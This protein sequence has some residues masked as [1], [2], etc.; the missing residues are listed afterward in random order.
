MEPLHPLATPLALLSGRHL[1]ASA[2]PL[3]IVF[4]LPFAATC[5]LALPLGAL[6]RL[7]QAQATVVEFA[8]K[9]AVAERTRRAEVVVVEEDTTTDPPVRVPRTV[10]DFALVLAVADAREALALGAPCAA[11]APRG[12]E[13]LPG[14]TTPFATSQPGRAPPC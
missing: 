11:A 12:D 7:A 14:P 8:A 5:L 1:S 9:T 10:A 3:V 4:V 13:W 2:R 6:P